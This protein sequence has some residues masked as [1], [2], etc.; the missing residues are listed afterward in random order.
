V[1]SAGELVLLGSE[2][3]EVMMGYVCSWYGSNKE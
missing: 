1:N 3:W 2:M